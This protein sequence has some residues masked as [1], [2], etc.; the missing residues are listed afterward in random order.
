[1]NHI[2][3]IAVMGVRSP[4][5]W[6]LDLKVEPAVAGLCTPEERALLL[7]KLACQASENAARLRQDM[8]RGG[9]LK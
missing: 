5:G 2:Q 3:L 9:L 1:M 7:E 6:T 4:D 8:A